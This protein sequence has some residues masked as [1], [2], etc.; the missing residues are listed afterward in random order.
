[1]YTQF[2]IKRYYTKYLALNVLATNIKFIPDTGQAQEQYSCAYGHPGKQT[3]AAFALWLSVL[4][5]CN[6]KACKIFNYKASKF[7]ILVKL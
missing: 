7:I 1:M 6:Y 4:K 2:F 3:R 5:S